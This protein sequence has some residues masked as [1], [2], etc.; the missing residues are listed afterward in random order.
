MAN[1]SIRLKTTVWSEK[2]WTKPWAIGFFFFNREPNC[3]VQNG[4]VR[5]E[6]Q[7]I[8]LL[9]SNEMNFGFYRSI[10]PFIYSRTTLHNLYIFSLSLPPTKVQQYLGMNHDEIPDIVACKKL[11]ILCL[12]RSR[13]LYMF[14][15]HYI[16]Y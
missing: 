7:L 13:R 1:G 12:V 2:S 3:T 8:F 6:V 16:I 10:S 9:T 4:S 11:V 5:L 15:I 14:F